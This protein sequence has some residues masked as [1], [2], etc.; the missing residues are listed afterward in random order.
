MVTNTQIL[1]K[2]C[3]EQEMSNNDGYDSVS[4]YFEFFS[5]AQILKNQILSDDEIEN[6]IVRMALMEVVIRYT[7]F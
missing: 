2:N 1:L 6:G 5:S 7:C 4:S 3:I